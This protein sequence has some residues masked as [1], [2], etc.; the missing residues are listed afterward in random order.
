MD[1]YK[2]FNNDQKIEFWSAH[3]KSWKESGLS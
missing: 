3:F 1:N 2:N